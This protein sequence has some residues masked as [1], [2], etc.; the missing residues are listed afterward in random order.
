M[1]CALRHFS[2]IRLFLFSTSLPI[3]RGGSNN[4]RENYSSLLLLIQFK[5]FFSIIAWKI[6]KKISSRALQGP[7]SLFPI[8]R[9]D[10]FSSSRT[11]LNLQVSFRSHPARRLNARK[12]NWK[13]ATNYPRLFDDDGEKGNRKSARID[14]DSLNRWMLNDGMAALKYVRLNETSSVWREGE[15]DPWVQLWFD[16]RNKRF[17]LAEI[18]GLM[19]RKRAWWRTSNFP[20]KKSTHKS[21]PESMKLPEA[22]CYVTFELD[23]DEK[24]FHFRKLRKTL[25]FPRKG[26]REAPPESSILKSPK[27]TYSANRTPKNFPFFLAKVFPRSKLCGLP[28]RNVSSEPWVGGERG[29]GVAINWI[30][31]VL[32][33]LRQIVYEILF[34][35]FCS[36]CR[37]IF[38]LLDN[39]GTNLPSFE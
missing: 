22:S 19:G 3:A 25:F 39:C 11:E 8:S 28:S 35:A 2:P 37:K 16:G 20:R 32:I 15:R 18:D 21:I 36:E 13:R 30:I 24:K 27:A 34:I 1:E 29:R 26:W 7:K 31:S 14:L 17:S 6:H 12:H 38:T 9:F 4:I 5:V 33:L 10:N 23:R